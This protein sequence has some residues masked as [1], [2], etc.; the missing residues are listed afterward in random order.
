MRD[1][2]R[3]VADLIYCA[4]LVQAGYEEAKIKEVLDVF[5][6]EFQRGSV[7]F[8]ITTKPREKRA[9]N[10]RFTLLGAQDDPL[11][12]A[13]AAGLII[14]Q[15]RLADKLVTQFRETFPLVGAS[16]DFSAKQGL[17]KMW[18]LMDP[19]FSLDRIAHM[20]ALPES[21]L[22]HAAFFERFHLIDLME[23]GVD[24]QRGSVNLY[25]AAERPQHQSSQFVKSIIQDRGF[26]M[27]SA[28]NISYCSRA[29]VVT[30]TFRW[31]SPRMER[32]AFYVPEFTPERVPSLHPILRPFAQRAPFLTDRRR[33]LIAWSF[34]EHGHY[35]KM[36]VDYTG[37]ELETEHW[38]H[39]T[40]QHALSVAGVG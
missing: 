13:L 17:V 29:V 25:F 21:I 22:T 18:Q 34:G 10:F 20:T 30:T 27:P 8:R 35:I 31:D 19:P 23:I 3:M 9:L 1:L 4:E 14:D 37:D 38:R 24:Y 15:G 26:A 32:M 7:Q 36:D 2:N 6:Y 40:Q 39:M 12:K 16:A 5:S 33:F 11:D 28:V